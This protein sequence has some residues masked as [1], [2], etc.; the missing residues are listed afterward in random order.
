MTDE[1]KKKTKGIIDQKAAAKKQK[2]IRSSE[3]IK[4]IKEITPELEKEGVPEAKREELE[5]KLRELCM[6]CCECGDTWQVA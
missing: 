3:L 2:R 4:A 1:P 6:P 5:K